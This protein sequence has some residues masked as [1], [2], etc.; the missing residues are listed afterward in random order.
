MFHGTQ[1]YGCTQRIQA[2]PGYTRPRIFFWCTPVHVLNRTC[3]KTGKKLPFSTPKSFGQLNMRCCTILHG[4]TLI[5][6][7]RGTCLASNKCMP[8]LPEVKPQSVPDW[9]SFYEKS[10]LYTVHT[11]TH[12]HT[13]T[14]HQCLLKRLHIMQMYIQ[15]DKIKHIGNNI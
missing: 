5:F 1:I 2:L 13:H 15:M 10:A 3:R 11:H 9:M 7:N 14:L 6:T 4:L 8:R 12:T